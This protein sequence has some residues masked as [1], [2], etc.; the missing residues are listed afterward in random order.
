MTSPFPHNREGFLQRS[1][2]RT[3][4]APQPERDV[5][6]GYLHPTKGYRRAPVKRAI[7]TQMTAEMRHGRS[8]GGLAGMRREFAENWR[9][10]S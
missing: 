2:F 10:E 1:R 6:D 9:S 7:A 5:T 4:N 3:K 8:Y